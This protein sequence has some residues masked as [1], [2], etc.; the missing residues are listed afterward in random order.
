MMI[1]TATRAEPDEQRGDQER[2]GVRRERGCEQ[3]HGAERDDGANQRTVLDEIA[4]RHDEEQPGAVADLRH[5]DDQPGGGVRQAQRGADR[6]DQRLGIVDVG[7]DH[8]TGR[9]KHE[10]QALRHRIRFGRGLDG[11]IHRHLHGLQ[12]L[13]TIIP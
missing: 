12:R 2:Q 9:G 10:G 8:A 7:G 11:G 3:R 4:E 5:G 6:G 13:G 1:C